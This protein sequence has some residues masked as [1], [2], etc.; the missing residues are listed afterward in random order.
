MARLGCARMLLVRSKGTTQH[1]MVSRLQTDAVVDLMKRQP[2]AM[3]GMTPGMRAAMGALVTAGAWHPDDI[4]K[5]MNLAQPP[6]PVPKQAVVRAKMQKFTPN[7]LHY[8]TAAEWERM[9]S[10]QS[11]GVAVDFLISRLHQLGGRCLSEPCKA[12]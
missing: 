12:W 10:Q 4:V 9:K 6:A 3:A 1:T 7:I 8:F 2:V 11:L 5:I